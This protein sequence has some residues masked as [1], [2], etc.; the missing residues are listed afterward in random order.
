M[1]IDGTDNLD[2]FLY[3]YNI[4]NKDQKRIKII[5]DF[6]KEKKELKYLDET[7]LNKIFYYRGKQAVLDILNF[8]I[9]KSKKLDNEL[10]SLQ[11][12]FKKKTLPSLPIGAGLLMSKYKIPEGKQLGIM[13]KL[14]EEEWVKNKDIGGKKIKNNPRY[15][16][17]SVLYVSTSMFLFSSKK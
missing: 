4:S 5:D 12:L 8:K 2:Y 7:K 16:S 14:I 3:K 9:V 1:I 13:L 17:D 6:F 15:G 11:E 10:I